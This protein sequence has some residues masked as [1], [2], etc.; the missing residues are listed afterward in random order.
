MTLFPSPEGVTVS[1]DLCTGTDLFGL[2][3]LA[4]STTGVDTI[5]NA[6]SIGG[7]DTA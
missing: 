4:L 6:G 7:I 2:A 3:S 5:T 1:G